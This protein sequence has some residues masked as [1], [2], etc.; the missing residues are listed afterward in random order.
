VNRFSSRWVRPTKGSCALVALNSHYHWML[1]IC[2]Y[3][4]RNNVDVPIEA[5]TWGTNVFHE[6]V[7]ETC[8][9]LEVSFKRLPD[10]GQY[11]EG[12]EAR[13]HALCLTEY[14]RVFM[15]DVDTYVV[16]KLP[17]LFAP[18]DAGMRLRAGELWENYRNPNFSK[19]FG[20]PQKEE[21][22]VNYSVWFGE[23]DRAHPQ[24]REVLCR[25]SD[26]LGRGS[27]I[28]REAGV[29]GDQDIR[30]GVLHAVGCP[31]ETID[32]KVNAW[33]TLQNQI[34]QNCTII[35]QSDKALDKESGRALI[36][37]LGEKLER[38][39]DLQL[40]YS[41]NGGSAMSQ[42]KPSPGL[43]LSVPILNRMKKIQGWLEDEEAD[44]L[45]ATCSR[46]LSSL[47]GDSAVVEVGSFCGRST[48]VLGSVIRSL[49]AKTKVYAVD[50]HDGV[51]GALDSETKSLGSTLEAFR[52]NIAENALTS[53]VEVVI[54]RSFEVAWQK[55]IAFLFIDGLHDYRSVSIDF[56]HFEPW[57]VAGGYIAFH[58]YA[59]Y[60]TGVKI[61]VDE[62]L[63]LPQFEHVHCAGS[64]MVI[65]KISAKVPAKVRP[66]GTLGGDR[67]G[68]FVLIGV[69][70][71]SRFPE[72]RRLV[73]ETWGTGMPAGLGALF[74]VGDSEESDEEGLVC[75]PV[76]DD[77]KALPAKVHAFYRYALAHYNFEYLFKCDDDTY[78]HTQRLKMLPRPGVDFLGS[79][80]ATSGGGG[81][82]M[83]RATVERFAAETVPPE[84][85]EDD[86]FS[87]LAR[88]LGARIETTHELQ[89][90]G[91][92][93]PEVH[94]DVVTGHW[95]G[96]PF[97]MRH[98]HA[99]MTGAA[100]GPRL[101]TLR[102]IHPAWSGWV[103]L[104]A[105]GSFWSRGGAD[106]NGSWSMADDDDALV[107]QWFHWPADTL[108]LRTWGFEGSGWRLEFMNEEEAS[109][110]F[111]TRRSKGG[112]SAKSA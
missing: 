39:E 1:P 27:D 30:N 57:V 33:E 45:I 97:E 7:V 101:L 110:F 32:V 21:G 91:D 72:R 103:R 112:Q 5:W 109:R 35:H 78:V 70:S 62:I 49:G 64:M 90:F 44:L 6:D 47:P 107:L 92:I 56:R 83:S 75:L 76:R 111:D 63:M 43:V 46:A 23:Y 19:F 13:H 86:V 51:V 68:L 58:D 71:C 104:Y 40:L 98:I 31:V 108:R 38:F 48:V 29:I 37:S 105:D 2:A 42:S 99:D 60:Y 89:G 9:A 67:D 36:E 96:G 82:L 4:L 106:P 100:P 54:N 12:W 20:L 73:R 15:L 55:S 10:T 26:L 53:V 25:T 8:R 87:A 17:W 3:F 84:G 77:Y 69:C 50:P 28:Y 11:C 34:Q 24:C 88:C 93:F 41:S 95:L 66:L 79:E 65:R 14:R 22:Y 80:G 74:F 81:Y 59:D 16:G 61:F 18:M 85:A 102:A 52:R 94:N